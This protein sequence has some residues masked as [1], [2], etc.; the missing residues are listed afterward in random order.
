MLDPDDDDLLSSVFL[1][2]D[3]KNDTKITAAIPIIERENFP[4][5]MLLTHRDERI[6]VE[7]AII[8]KTNQM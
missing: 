4:I 6:K 8:N 5:A 7:N 3:M 2:D 1:T